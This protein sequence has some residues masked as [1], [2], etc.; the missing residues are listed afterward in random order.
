MT[1]VDQGSFSFHEQKDLLTELK[2]LK[3]NHNVFSGHG[4]IFTQERCELL[5]L[6]TF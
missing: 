1:W 4:A 3:G 6:V 2:S 5:S